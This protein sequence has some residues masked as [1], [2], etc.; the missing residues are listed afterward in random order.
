MAEPTSPDPADVKPDDEGIEEVVQDAKQL[1]DPF[2]ALY[3]GL[4]LDAEEALAVTLRHPA[5]LVVFAE[6]EESGKTT[7]L[8]TIY[9]NLVQ[10]P[11]AGFRFAGSRL[12]LSFLSLFFLPLSFLSLFFLPLSFLSLFFLP[13]SF[14]SLFFLPLSL[15]F[16]SFVLL[17]LHA[18]H[19]EFPLLILISILI[20]ILP[21]ELCFA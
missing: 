16:L 21:G 6:G 11:F 14:L 9:E 15:S 1:E 7:I 17:I 3:P 8:A 10:G 4:A 20:L 18:L 12:P 2:V 13:L 19:G 5:H